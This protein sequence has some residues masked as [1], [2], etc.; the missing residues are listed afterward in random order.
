MIAYDYNKLEL[1]W[2]GWLLNGKFSF[3]ALPDGSHNNK[4]MISIY[5][6]C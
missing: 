2:T 1:L 6:R 3:K 4:K 5:F